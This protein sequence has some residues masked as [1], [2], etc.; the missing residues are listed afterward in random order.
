MHAGYLGGV[1]AAIKWQMPAGIASLIVGLQ[2]LLTAVLGHFWL[3]GSLHR[4]QWLGLALGLLGIALV[5]TNG[6]FSRTALSS[7][8]NA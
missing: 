5:I 2:P 1:F 3:G 7:V 6:E 8:C 4:S